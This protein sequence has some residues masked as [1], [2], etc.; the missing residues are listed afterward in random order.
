MTNG[1]PFSE[2]LEQ[3]GASDST[4]QHADV[5]KTYKET[6]ERT[7]KSSLAPAERKLRPIDLADGAVVR[8]HDILFG[9]G[10]KVFCRDRI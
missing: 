6:Y 4:A 7:S 1:V 10:D 8:K 9:Q 3:H 2:S 5:P